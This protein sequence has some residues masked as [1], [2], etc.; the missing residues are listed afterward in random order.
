M[1]FFKRAWQLPQREWHRIFSKV[2][3]HTIYF[4]SNPDFS[5]N[6]RALFEYMIQNG[7][8]HKYKIYWATEDDIEDFSS[9]DNV[10]RISKK[11]KRQVV[12]ALYSSK[13]IFY[14]HGLSG[15]IR[16]KR[17]Q[18]VVNLWHGCG[19]KASRNKDKK[20]FNISVLINSGKMI[21]DYVLVPGE[22][23]IET[24]SEFFRCA[25]EKILPIGYPRYDL[26]QEG[27]NV[28]PQVCAA[29][30]IKPG[31]R[32]VI[33]MPTY[34]QTGDA[35]YKEGSMKNQY[36]LPLLR[37]D[38]DL[39]KLDKLCTEKNISLIIKK[40]RSQSVFK[41]DNNAVE[42][43]YFIDDTD[44]RKWN[45]QLYSILSYTDALI[46][47][48]SSIAIDYL[49][50]DKPIGFTLDD[51]EEYK[52]LRGFVFDDALNYMPGHHIYEMKQLETFFDDIYQKND[53]YKEK[54]QSL[55]P[56]M[57]NPSENYCRRI[58]DYFDI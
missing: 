25:K 38:N 42:S 28:W 47:D 40:H 34:R 14:T 9:I 20:W 48:Y 43:I 24:K 4:E 5:D 7:L 27:C 8:H 53:I 45:I 30:K 35:S 44:L 11:N 22:A 18:T 57:H 58:I 15:W 6:A 51:Y 3:D 19:Y 2:D 52:A 50:L 23:F 13:Y 55:L 21:F 26:F 37:N 12:R 36:W 41:R 10:S 16:K 29:W 17:E 46:T 32:V 1:K 39:R 49:L 54:R 31:S 33:W 56:S